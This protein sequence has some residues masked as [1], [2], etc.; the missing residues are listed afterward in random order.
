[1]RKPYGWSADVTNLTMPVML[2]YGDSDM[3]GRSTK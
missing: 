3:F 2:I 1:M